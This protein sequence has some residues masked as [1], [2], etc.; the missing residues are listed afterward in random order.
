MRAEAETMEHAAKR[1]MLEVAAS[2]EALADQLER[3]VPWD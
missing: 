1:L 3:P 2:Y